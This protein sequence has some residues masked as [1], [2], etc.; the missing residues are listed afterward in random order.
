M[1]SVYLRDGEYEK[2]SS[3]PSIA[4]IDGRK[5]CREQFAFRISAFVQRQK[6]IRESGKAFSISF[7]GFT[8]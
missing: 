1:T 3:I 4:G 8:D 6:N 5:T 2:R 7:A